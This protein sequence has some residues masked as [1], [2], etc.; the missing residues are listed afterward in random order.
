MAQKKLPPK[1]RSKPNRFTRIVILVWIIAGVIVLTTIFRALKGIGLFT[2][3][4]NTAPA[5]C[6]A[7]ALPGPGDL[8]YESKSKT[9]FIA[10][11]R[12][13]APAAS[14][15]IYALTPGT[16]KATKLAGTSADFHPSAVSVGYDV[17]GAPVLMTVSRDRNGAASVD[18]FNVDVSPAGLALSS[19]SAIQGGLAR[20]GQGIASLGNSRFYLAGNPTRSDLFAWADRNLALGRADILFFNG[21][22][23]REA[24]N[25]LSDPSA[26]AVSPDGAHV[27]VGSRNERRL[28]GFSREPMTGALTELG[29]LALPMRPERASVDDAGTV[30]VAGPARLPS[31]SA[32]SVVVRVS[33]T[34]DG[35]PQSVDTVY[36]GDGI[37]A[38]TA[39]VKT[40]GHLF[41]GS[42]H[43]DKLLDCAMK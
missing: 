28:I 26:V 15:G 13:G 40:D 33:A 2:F 18:I 24:I 9:L 11:A 3:V 23:F 38:A 27:Y 10:V 20:R 12:D 19:Q 25:G 14:D 5:S 29:A 8:A 4:G 16:A 7:I 35:K 43:D 21:T 31:L 32:D 42:R 30:W 34:P 41:I 36:A 22:L 39:A 1:A 17:G 37:K 6:H